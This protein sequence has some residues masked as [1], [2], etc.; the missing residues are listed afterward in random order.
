[1]A[2]NFWPNDYDF[3]RVVLAST[4]NTLQADTQLDVEF[5]EVSDGPELFA[6][7]ALRDGLTARD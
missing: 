2:S 5:I 4:P 7:Q 6:N 3:V 1:M